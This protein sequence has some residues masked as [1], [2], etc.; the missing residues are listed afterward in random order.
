MFLCKYMLTEHGVFPHEVLS[1]SLREKLVMKELLT[2][3]SKEL[4]RI[5][6]GKH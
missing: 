6:D 1:L 2:R 5:K 3:H 4:K